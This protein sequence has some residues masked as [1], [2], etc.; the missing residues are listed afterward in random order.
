MNYHG[1][2]TIN[3]L[4]SLLPPSEKNHLLQL[5]TPALASVLPATDAVTE[6]HSEPNMSMS[7]L[8]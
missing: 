2:S 5:Q 6:S 4:S 1:I 7:E 3:M 8:I